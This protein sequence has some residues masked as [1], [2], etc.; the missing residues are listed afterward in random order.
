MGLDSSR[1]L[2]VGDSSWARLLAADNVAGGSK[3]RRL[4]ER[5]D[6]RDGARDGGRFDVENILLRSLDADRFLRGELT[7]EFR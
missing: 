4:S 5:S 2:D 6:A 7:G 3:G 1:D